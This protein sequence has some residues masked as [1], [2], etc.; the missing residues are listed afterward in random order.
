MGRYLV[1]RLATSVVLFFAITLFVFVAFSAVPSSSGGSQR[2]VGGDAYRLHGSLPHRYADYV[3]NLVRH[4]DLGRSY[5]D[6]EAVTTR[7]FRA[8][9][10]TL[11]LVLGGLIVWLL[12]AI[13]LGV[14]SALR[15]RS[16]LDRGTT[17]FVLIGLSAHPLWLGLILGYVFGA[18]WHVFPTG[19]YCDL[20]S[21]S[22]NCGGPAQWGYHLLLPWLVLGLLNAALFTMMIRAVVREELDH[23]YVRTARATGLGETRVLRVHVFKNVLPPFVTMIGMSMG[24]A[25]GG[26]I[27]IESAFGLPGLGRM[28]RRSIMQQDVP[29]TAGIV[30]FMTLA[31]MLLNLVVDLGYAALDPRVRLRRADQALKAT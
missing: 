14:L 1:G 9:P 15:P 25:L 13:P 29:M 3:W 31:I 28:L 6:R 27:F 10:V 24:I 5:A 16:L 11:S 21:P 17:V 19:G 7:L 12:I 23:D 26:V 8:A 2:S 22:T 20:F 18:H 4:G 30:M